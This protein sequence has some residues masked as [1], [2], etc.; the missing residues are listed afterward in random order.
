MVR[1]VADKLGDV[2]ILVNSAGAT[3]A[4]FRTIS[5]QPHGTRR[6]M[7]YFI[8]TRWTRCC[9]EW[10]P[11]Q[12]SVVVSAWAAKSPVDPARQGRERGAD[13]GDGGPVSGIRAQ[14]YPH[15]RRQPGCDAHR[16]NQEG[17]RVEALAR[18]TTEEEVLALGQARVPLRRYANPEEIAEVALFLA[19]DKA[20]Y[21]TGAII[22]MDGGSNP[23]I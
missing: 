8:F 10:P 21:V 9:L 1:E 15:Q 12:G 17:L 11:G 5:T 18:K 16:S 3:S 13:A 20:S 7:Q 2:D 23:V 22:P 19:S 6:W 14:G 4:I